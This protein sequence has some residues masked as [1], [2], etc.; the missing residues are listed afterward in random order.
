MN[1]TRWQYQVIEH[2]PSMMG[3]IKIDDL[4]DEL[5]KLGQQGWEL[6]SLT[7]TMPLNHLIAVLK[8]GA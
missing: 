3:G 4:K 7:P 8:R 1:D 6:V 5:D 2:K